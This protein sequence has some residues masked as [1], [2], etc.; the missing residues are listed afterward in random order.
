MHTA[1]RRSRIT[2]R[3]EIIGESSVTIDLPRLG[4]GTRAGPGLGRT[5]LAPGRNQDAP[6]SRL[7]C[8][9]GHLW[10]VPAQ[11]TCR[12]T[13]PQTSGFA[14]GAQG[15]VRKS[16]TSASLGRLQSFSRLRTCPPL[17]ILPGPGIRSELGG[18]VPSRHPR[19]QV[20]KIDSTGPSCSAAGCSVPGSSATAG[21]GAPTNSKACM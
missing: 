18:S 12:C 5:T 21:A 15:S 19:T 1:H 4:R 7:G 6:G 2:P 3:S 17:G 9:I 20:F 13:T 10:T 11:G 14:A 8:G 16:V